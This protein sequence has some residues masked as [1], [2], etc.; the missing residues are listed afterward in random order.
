NNYVLVASPNYLRR[1]PIPKTLA[2]L[3]DHRALLYRSPNRVLEWQAETSSGW[4]AVNI[5]PSLICNIGEELVQEAVAGAG[6]ALVP[7]WGCEHRLI[8]KELV[9]VILED[10]KLSLSRDNESGTCLLYHQPKYRLK[11]VKAAVDFLVA[12]LTL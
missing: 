7:R 11:K 12:E 4:S 5:Q 1:Y 3:S 8:N 9:S 10:A 2:D 6:L